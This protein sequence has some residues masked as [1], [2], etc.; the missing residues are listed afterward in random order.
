VKTPHK[1][2]VDKAFSK[3]RNEI[4][5]PQATLYHVEQTGLTTLILD[6][7]K[8]RSVYALSVQGS[9]VPTTPTSKGAMDDLL[10]KA[11]WQ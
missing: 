7:D 11:G 4:E 3:S 9:W 2:R 10:G 8:G 6:H 5:V 1:A